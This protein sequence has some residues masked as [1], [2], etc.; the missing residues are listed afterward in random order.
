MPIS[1]DN[2]KRKT[3]FHLD[4]RSITAK[5][6]PKK[7][8]KDEGMRDWKHLSPN[9]PPLPFLSSKHSKDGGNPIKN[10]DS[11]T[12]VHMTPSISRTL[13][14]ILESSETSASSSIRPSH[15]FEKDDRP[16]SSSFH[17]RTYHKPPLQK[18][19]KPSS[20]VSQP[21]KDEKKS[22]M[23]ATYL[24]IYEWPEHPLSCEPQ[25][26]PELQFNE[27][28]SR[29]TFSEMLI[30]AYRLFQESASYPNEIY[31]VFNDNDSL[32]GFT[33]ILHDGTR[34]DYLNLGGSLQYLAPELIS[35]PS[36]HY[37][38]IEVWSLGVSL[39]RMLIGKYPFDSDGLSDRE[40]L[41]RMSKSN[42]DIPKQISE[43][44]KD[45]IQKML[46]PKNSRV[47]LET[48]Q[49]HP[50]L[51]EH[52]PKEEVGSTPIK[53][54]SRVKETGRLLLRAFRFIFKG[55][56]PPP[57]SYYDLATLTRARAS[58]S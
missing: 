56:Y 2:N 42:L 23:S 16:S 54:M 53:Q 46:S 25:F 44:A 15:S 11:M 37:D 43:D 41:D 20:V 32:K 17:P 19:A 22:I 9:R 47:S 33:F 27:T 31:L 58:P 7:T 34:E 50:W 24:P 13:Y 38:R 40:L 8:R 12:S 14:P 29:E 52:I 48:V 26:D 10:S 39:F 35:D 5:L 30:M 1:N 18:F 4:V 36:F 3:W 55:P 57:A 28:K 45:L 49:S 21:A 51:D 6:S